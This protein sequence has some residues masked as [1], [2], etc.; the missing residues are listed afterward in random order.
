MYRDFLIL[1]G[2]GLVGTQVV[3]KIVKTFG[4]HR[5]VVGSLFEQEAV[6]ACQKFE[7][8]FGTGVS[9]VPEWGDLFLP[10]ELS[11]TRRAE[12][13]ADT[14]KRAALLNSLY[15][16]FE[17]AYRDNQLVKLIRRHRPDVMVDCVNTATGLSYQDVFDGAAKVRERIGPDGFD[18]SHTKDLET[19]LLSQSVPQLIRHVRFIHRATIEYK[20]KVYLKVGTTGTGGMGMNI[21]YTHSE[22]SPSR[23]LLAKTE[24]AF[25]HT[26]LLFLLSR[27]PGAPI[28]K[29]VKPAAMIGYKAVQVKTVRDKHNNSNLFGVKTEQI[30]KGATLELR[31]D[32]AAYEKTGELNVAI[33]DTGENGLFTRGEF[34]AITALGQMEY[35]TPEEIAQIVVRELR[36]AT[37]GRDV[38][39]ALDGA[40]LDPS[41]KAGLV[42]N[43]AL[44]DLRLVEKGS[45]EDGTGVPSIALGRLGPPALSKLLFEAALLKKVYATMDDMVAVR[46]NQMAKALEEALV[47]MRFD[48]LAPSIGVPVL[49]A[50]GKTL[51]RGPRIN[52]PELLGHGT[53]VTIDAGDID[54]WAAKGW[55]DLRPSNMDVWI[56]RVQR[57]VQARRDLRMEGSAAATIESYMS[58]KF[59]IGEVVAWIFNNEMGGYRIK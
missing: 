45:L 33:V 23:K 24:V 58:H 52:V 22:D 56:R 47:G 9:F 32:E 11:T 35:V 41:Y 16:D 20:T 31:Q 15:G 14:S 19:F 48:Q 6:A 8:Q 12:L 46:P 18:T 54:V 2:A 1:G 7:R 53:T 57:M 17:E 38:I 43:V 5:I 37:T 4:A 42:R 44:K 36:G 3:R 51:M 34:E 49:L 50:D 55:V 59:E 30:A 28:V 26:G 27:T 21:P 10:S 29:E 40:V 39:S 13:L 25:G